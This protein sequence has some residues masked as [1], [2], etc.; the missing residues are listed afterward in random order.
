MVYLNGLEWFKSVLIMKI[1]NNPNHFLMY[2]GFFFIVF[3]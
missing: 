2:F 3:E 1:S